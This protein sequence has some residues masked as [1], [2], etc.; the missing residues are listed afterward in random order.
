[1]NNAPPRPEKLKI[2]FTAKERTV[3]VIWHFQRVVQNTASKGKT[4]LGAMFF[5]GVGEAQGKGYR[6]IQHSVE[7]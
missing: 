1:M 2:Y 6:L 3:L 4:E 5:S 7:T